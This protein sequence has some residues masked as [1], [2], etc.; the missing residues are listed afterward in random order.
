[1]QTRHSLSPQ[2]GNVQ[3][4]P[5]VDISELR[6][7]LP[8]NSFLLG[9]TDILS[10]KRCFRRKTKTRR[11]YGH[12]CPWFCSEA[13]F[14]AQV[15]NSTSNKIYGCILLGRARMYIFHHNIAN[16]LKENLSKLKFLEVPFSNNNTL[17]FN[18]HREINQKLYI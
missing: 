12:G 10:E 11:Q 4:C 8:K 13:M 2:D 1:M 18:K 17:S 7:C 16:K 14:F 6:V 3:K 5:S 15:K 9:N